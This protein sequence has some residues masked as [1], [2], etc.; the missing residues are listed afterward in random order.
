M[1]VKG[2]TEKVA[3][4]SSI[5]SRQLQQIEENL[6]KMEAEEAAASSA[7]SVSKTVPANSATV[8]AQALAPTARFPQATPATSIA[9]PTAATDNSTTTQEAVGTKW[10]TVNS[11]QSKEFNKRMEAIVKAKETVSAST[12]RSLTILQDVRDKAPESLKS[13]LNSV[14]NQAIST[15][16]RVKAESTGTD[17][18]KQ[19]THNAVDQDKDDGSDKPGYDP[20][21]KSDRLKNRDNLNTDTKTFR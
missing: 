20:A 13:S 10:D 4:T 9:A 15:S 18:N 3:A 14:I 5:L 16:K 19:N 7:A 1:T 8:S 21:F 12:T 6:A 17:S 11:K 2:N